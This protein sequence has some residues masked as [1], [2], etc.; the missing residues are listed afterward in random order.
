MRN[1]IDIP[2]IKEEDI[3]AA[4]MRRDKYSITR[5]VQARE[6]NEA[7]VT[8]LL[9]ESEKRIKCEK[10]GKEFTISSKENDVLSCLECR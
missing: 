3:I 2:I 8:R 10:C 4:N 9:A 1:E 5:D 6:F 7:I